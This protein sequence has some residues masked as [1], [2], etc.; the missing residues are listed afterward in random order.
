LVASEPC[1]AA[2]TLL[3]RLPRKPVST[4]TV[5]SAVIVLFDAIVFFKETR[6]D[7]TA[8][9]VSIATVLMAAKQIERATVD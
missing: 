9:G 8:S 6:R 3:Q 2:A 5:T 4:K 7:F 1:V